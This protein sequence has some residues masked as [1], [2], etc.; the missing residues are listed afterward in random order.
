MKEVN[1]SLRKNSTWQL[2]LLF[3]LQEVS[4]YLMNFKKECL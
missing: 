4:L 1:K 2:S 3:I